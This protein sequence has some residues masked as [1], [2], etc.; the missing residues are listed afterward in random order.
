VRIADTLDIAMQ[1]TAKEL[2][3]AVKLQLLKQGLME[4]LLS[5]RVRVTADSRDAA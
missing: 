4:D 5:G 1:R 2:R 3:L